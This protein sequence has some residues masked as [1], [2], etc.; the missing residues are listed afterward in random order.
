M[1]RNCWPAAKHPS[2]IYFPPVWQTAQTL[3][4]LDY[5]ICKSYVRI[6]GKGCLLHYVLMQRVSPLLGPICA[7][8][9]SL[10]WLDRA[11]KASWMF[12]FPSAK[13]ILLLESPPKMLLMWRRL[14][15]VRRL[16]FIFIQESSG[17]VLYCELKN[18]S[19]VPAELLSSVLFY[20]V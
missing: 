19:W 2:H 6:L 1:C 10:K 16:Y 13:L 18:C 15:W 20:F 11:H 7:F 12:T 17:A 9:Y 3:W 8:V 5:I 4:E 14:A